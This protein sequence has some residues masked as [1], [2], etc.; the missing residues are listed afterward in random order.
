MTQSFSVVSRLQVTVTETTVN[1]G[2]QLHLVAHVV[3]APLVQFLQHLFRL[4]QTL[5]VIAIGLS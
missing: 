2:Q 4:L 5:L 1:V 3:F